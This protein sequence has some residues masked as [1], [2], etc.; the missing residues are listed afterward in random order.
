[1]KSTRFVSITLLV[2]LVL[3][4]FITST[5][6]SVVKTDSLDDYIWN[7][8]LWFISYSKMLACSYMGLWGIFILDDNGLMAER[9]FA[10]GM[11]GARVSFSGYPV[12][13]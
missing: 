4:C 1:M 8:F 11:P 5:R 7:W 13:R 6:A 2:F 3:T 12:H 10:T 9:C